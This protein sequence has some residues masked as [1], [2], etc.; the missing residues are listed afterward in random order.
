MDEPPPPPTPA[1]PENPPRRGIDPGDPPVSGPEKPEADDADKDNDNVDGDERL[2]KSIARRPALAGLPIRATLD[3]GVAT[4][5]GKVPSIFEAML[6]F[7]A[8]QKSPGVHEVVDRLQFAVPPPKGKNPLVDRGRPEDVEP[9]L[10]A[11]MQRQLGEIANVDRVRV[12]GDQL[13]VSGTVI[14]DQEQARINAI[15]RSMP[16]LR[17]F[18]VAA[19][20][21][22]E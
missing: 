15:L 22:P 20:F 19:E 2:Q 10:L 5:S 21:L 11:Q 17:G 4:I 13:E 3:Q 14:S 12:H 6:A 16:A 18:Q 7:R 8:V 1:F 9:Y